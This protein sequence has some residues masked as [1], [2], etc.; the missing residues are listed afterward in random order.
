MMKSIKGK[1][2]LKKLSKPEEVA[3]FCN[4]LYFTIKSG[5]PIA[6]GL[7]IM[8]EDMPKGKMKEDIRV[9]KEQLEE[10]MALEE[11]LEVGGRFPV[12]MIQTI[13]LAH[14]LGREEESM[15]YLA[16]YYEKQAELKAL[17]KSAVMGPSMLIVI[18]LG[19][20]IVLFIEVIPLFD[21]IFRNIGSS[22][23]SEAPLLVAVKSF[24]SQYGGLVGGVLIIILLVLIVVRRIYG[25]KWL[26]GVKRRFKISEKIAVAQLAQIL[27]V[28]LKS[29]IT[30]EQA[31]ELALPIIEHPKVKKICGRL[32]Q[33]LDT[34]RSFKLLLIDTKLFSPMMTKLLQLGIEAGTLD[35]AMEKVAYTYE[36]EVK[37]QIQTVIGMIEPSVVGILCMLISGVLLSIIL[38]LM[39]IMSAIV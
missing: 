27:T 9:I 15:Q 8:L 17:I 29:G 5:L 33:E 34:G 6:E 12:H 1:V 36:E 38:P 35:V 7:D 2:H 30:L 19:V 32:L 4:A 13:K 24:L 20:L 37:K 11:A 39:R 21:Q 18:L 10:G 14:L 16:Q 25:E 3:I 26:R 31:I 23:A 22:L 28:S